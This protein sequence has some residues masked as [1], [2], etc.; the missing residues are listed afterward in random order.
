MDRH[1]DSARS[2]PWRTRTGISS[3]A[4]LLS[5]LLVIPLL[6]GLAWGTYFDDNAYATF[7][8]ARDLAYGRGHNLDADKAEPTSHGSPLYAL[9]LSLPAVLRIPLPQASLVLSSLGWGA[10]AVV[11]YSLGK[12]IHQ[13]VAALVSATLIVFSPIVVSTLGTEVAWLAASAWIAIASSVKK[14]WRIQACGMALMLWTSFDLSTVALAGLLLAIQWTE[15]RDFPLLPALVLATAGLGWGLVALRQTAGLFSLLSV[16]TLKSNLT[17]WTGFIQRL[18]GESEFYWLC[19]PFMLAG[20][21][22]P[23]LRAL[24]PAFLWGVLSI[25]SSGREAGAPAVL[26]A[27]L[28]GLGI[29]KVVRWLEPRSF[30]RI[31]QPVVRVGLALIAGLPVGMAQASSILQRHRLRPVIRHELEQRVGD[32]LRVHGEPMATVFGSE[33]IGYLADRSAIP[34]DGSASDQVEL[35][36]L[37]NALS[38]DPPDYCV[39][40]NS[41]AWDHLSRTGWFRHGYEPLETFESP[42]DSASPLIIWGHRLGVVDQGEHRSLNVRLPG[43]IDLVEYTYWPDR[44]NPGDTVHVTLFLQATRPVTETFQAIV[45]MSLPRDAGDW[46]HWLH[47]DRYADRSV[48]VGWWQHGQVIAERFALEADADLP[49][50][51]Y[52]LDVSILASDSETVLPVYRN[53]DTS[54]VDRIMLGYV[55]VPWHGTLDRAKQ[56]DA[57]LGNQISLLGFEAPDVLVPGTEFDVTLYWEAVRP[58]EDNYI[59]FVHLV[60]ANG[61]ASASHD[62][63]PMDGKYPTR[64]WRAGEVVPDTHR[65]VLDPEATGG[66]HRL[67]VGMYRWPSL[68]RLLV[69]DK[70]RV[71]QPDRAIVLQ[72][73]EIR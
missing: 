24:W 54:P 48:P 26:A 50:G 10:T 70:E 21:L 19:V 43:G 63:P 28:T 17:E 71:E 55:V 45:Q 12:A 51:A 3:E 6:I 30:L 57:I 62:R 65:L 53:G 56:V 66:T 9:A 16:H 59:V 60:D 68:E 47:V 67:L 2:S 13:P 20:L 14:Q 36:R 5:T 32:W 22:S 37:L 33:R 1:K 27:F 31:S 7:R 61:E 49:I 39:S 72:S 42:Y 23:A 44:I 38:D 8:H 11:L 69:R 73:I 52:R 18:L 41:L 46:M 64:A 25:L 34:W 4:I 29:D 40:Y 15:T 58:P 35:A